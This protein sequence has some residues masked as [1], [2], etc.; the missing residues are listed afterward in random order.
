[1]EIWILAALAGWCPT[2]WP[3]IPRWP[4][5]PWWPW[6]WP[7]PPWPGPGPEPDPPPIYL[8]RDRPLEPI[9][10]GLFGAVGGIAAWAVLG[11]RFGSDGSLVGVVVISFLGGCFGLSIANTLDGLRNRGVGQQPAE[12]QR[13]T[14]VA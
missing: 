3:R 1:M 12:A 5:V 7:R 14:E 2:G 4:W 6:P 9:T 13:P 11:P 10:L 8:P